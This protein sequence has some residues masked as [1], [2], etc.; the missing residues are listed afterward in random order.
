MSLEGA[1]YGHDNDGRRFVPTGFGLL[2][3]TRRITT[4][5][6]F[7]VRTWR[8]RIG[9][10]DRDISDQVARVVGRKAAEWLETHAAGK[11]RLVCRRTLL[12]NGRNVAHDR[13]LEFADLDLCAC[14]VEHHEATI[15]SLHLADIE[16]GLMSDTA[17]LR[18]Q[19]ES[20]VY[21]ASRCSLLKGRRQMTILR[22]SLSVAADVLHAV[23]AL[24]TQLSLGPDPRF[25][26]LRCLSD[27]G[28]VRAESRNGLGS[29]HDVVW[30][31]RFDPSQLPP[32]A[33]WPASQRF[34]RLTR[35]ELR[36]HRSQSRRRR[37]GR[38]D[39]L[40]EPPGW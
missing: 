12:P 14:F 35:K 37:T 19:V 39:P 18:R 23:D 28:E 38:L 36:D 15:L 24:R 17:E 26:W 13:V 16:R 5:P 33:W 2:L 8:H 9:S 4:I 40:P 27:S 6:A 32:E 31:R 21:D 10:R 25:D 1:D 29:L 11:W 3:G 22:S 34:L 7:A 30:S 20:G